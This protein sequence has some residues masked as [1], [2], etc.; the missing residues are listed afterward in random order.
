MASLGEVIDAQIKKRMK[1][2]KF[3]EI[4]KVTSVYNI[5]QD[6]LS[7]NKGNTD[8]LVDV[9]LRSSPEWGAGQTGMTATMNNVPVC[10]N[11]VGNGYGFITAPNVGDV[12]VVGFMMGDTS[13]P[14]V[15]GRFYQT[16]STQDS[17]YSKP[18]DWNLDDAIFKHKSGSSAKIAASGDITI[19]HKTGATI[20]MDS[21]GNILITSKSGSDVKINNGTNGAARI[22]D[23]TSATVVGDHGS[24][25][26]TIAAGSVHVK[27]G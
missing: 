13:Q 10:S 24:H 21:S 1:R 27:I 9:K 17:T 19:T 15:L 4:G 16:E 11:Y 14:I 2:I 20:I 7:S 6:H 22:G 18:Q 3:L 12:V 8:Y 23:I 5:S 26:H 25:T